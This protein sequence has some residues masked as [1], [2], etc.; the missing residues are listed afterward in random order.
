MNMYK[1]EKKR[2][3]STVKQVSY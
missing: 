1:G 3:L 2:W